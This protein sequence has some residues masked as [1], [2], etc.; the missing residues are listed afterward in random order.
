LSETLR[1]GPTQWDPGRIFT[2]LALIER[3]LSILGEMIADLVRFL[4]ESDLG[5]RSIKRHERISW[6]VG[7]LAR[8]AMFCNVSKLRAH[9]GPC[10]VGFFGERRTA[11]D[12]GPLEGA[13]SA[14]VAQFVDYPGILSYSSVE[15]PNG[16]WANLVLHDDP[17]DTR[18][19][20]RGEL[21]AQ[22]ARTLSPLHYRNVRIHNARLTDRLEGSPG[23]DLLR[24]KYWDYEG[25][26]GWSA[27]RELVATPD[28]PTH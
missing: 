10:A 19:W 24:T 7:G 22:A 12:M 16:Y 6:V 8:R 5:V 18:Y 28:R 23:F 26:D 17:V 9:L 14:I 15:L 1:L 21:H 25:T 27:V 3:D 13:N 11:L 2:S 4:H 20:S